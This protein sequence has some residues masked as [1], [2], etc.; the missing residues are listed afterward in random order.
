MVFS[1]ERHG[2]QHQP[3]ASAYKGALILAASDITVASI[4]PTTGVAALQRPAAASDQAAKDLV[5]KAF[6][7]C[8]A[9][10][11]DYVADCPQYLADFAVTDVQ[12]SLIGDPATGAALSFDPND[13][14]LTVAGSFEM[15]ASFRSDGHPRNPKRSFTTA[16]TAYLMWDGQAL[17]LVTIN[18]AA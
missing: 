3:A 15:R 5:S 16:Y 10:Q 6:V 8:A 17:Q 12:W 4:Q 18:G 7:Q 13:G 1:Y 11:R 2:T 14:L 9:A